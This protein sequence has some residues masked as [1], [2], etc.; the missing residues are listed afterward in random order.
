MKNVRLG[1]I[2]IAVLVLGALSPVA[3]A[4]M[5][6]FN[7]HVH[8]QSG[9]RKQV[10]NAYSSQFQGNPIPYAIKPLTSPKHGT[11]SIER[12]SS[13]TKIYYQSAKGYLGQDS[14]QYVRVSDDKFGGTYTVA[15]TVR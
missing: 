4:M 9:E 3:L 15:V 10:G 13:E 7:Y 1:S 5:G 14:F 6:G 8:A 11:M 2:P 12:G